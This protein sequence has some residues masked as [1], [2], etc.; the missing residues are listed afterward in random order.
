MNRTE[1]IEQLHYLSVERYVLR[2]ESA[3]NLRTVRAIDYAVKYFHDE[4]RLLNLIEF[5]N[6]G[7]F[8]D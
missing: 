6:T 2:K 8:P 1:I 4:L 3:L 7:K 5:C